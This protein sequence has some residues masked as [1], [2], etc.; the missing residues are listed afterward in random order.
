M[1]SLHLSFPICKVGTVG[2]VM[3]PEAGNTAPALTSST[4][5][6]VRNAVDALKENPED[7]AS[8]T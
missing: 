2:E 4:V 1:P 6:G 8:F 7:W 5:P 3:C